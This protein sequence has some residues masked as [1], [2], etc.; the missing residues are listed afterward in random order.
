MNYSNRHSHFFLDGN[1]CFCAL[2]CTTV[3]KTG[4]SLV[5]CFIFLFDVSSGRLLTETRKSLLYIF[6]TLH[7]K[8]TNR[9]K[10]QV[11]TSVLL[12]CETGTATASIS[13]LL[14]AKYLSFHV[15]CR[16]LFTKTTFRIA[17]T[18]HKEPLT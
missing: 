11:Y 1:G 5:G 8:V 12:S 6:G 10:I 4:Y 7:L 18:S 14:S 2:S 17:N 9:R 3:H 15:A 16:P 13:W